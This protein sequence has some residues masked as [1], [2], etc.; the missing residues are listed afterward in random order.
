[1]LKKSSQYLSALI[2]SSAILCATF[3]THTATRMLNDSLQEMNGGILPTATLATHH[4][5][6]K[7]GQGSVEKKA[8]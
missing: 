1:M 4:F 7:N 5:L 8:G 6:L 3:F 2:S